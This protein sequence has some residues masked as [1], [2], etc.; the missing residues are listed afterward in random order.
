MTKDRV[1]TV[2]LAT[3]ENETN[4]DRYRAARDQLVAA[5]TDYDAAWRTFEWPNLSCE[6]NWATDWFDAIARHNDRRA[7]WI[8]EEDGAEQQISFSEM[9]DR[10]DRVAS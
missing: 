10:S 1:A 9:A 2:E 8:V 6:F 5:I 4:T 7:L 3:T